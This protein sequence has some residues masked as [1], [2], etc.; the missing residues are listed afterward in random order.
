[1]IKTLLYI[2]VIMA[3]ISLF[4]YELKVKG[5]VYFDKVTQIIIT[6]EPDIDGHTKPKEKVTI[7]DPEIMEKLIQPIKKKRF[8]DDAEKCSCAHS[9]IIIVEYNNG[10][11]LS[12]GYFEEERIGFELPSGQ[13]GIT[14]IPKEYLS[15]VRKII[16][17]SK[18]W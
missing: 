2:G 16:E 8:L 17:E 14:N 6:Y 12:I 11:K 9:P 10:F 3:I 4:W 13:N 7:T 15:N 18:K 1:M 5:L